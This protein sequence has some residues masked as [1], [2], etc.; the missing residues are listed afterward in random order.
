LCVGKWLCHKGLEL[1]YRVL[2]VRSFAA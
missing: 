1:G 2:E